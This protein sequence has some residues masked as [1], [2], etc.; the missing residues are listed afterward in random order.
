[1]LARRPRVRPRLAPVLAERA[2]Q[3]RAAPTAT[4]A[5]LWEQLRGSQLGVGF[6]RQL[7]IER[8][9]ADFACPARR[10][11]VEV[12]G[13]Y[14]QLPAAQRADARRDTVLARLGWRVVRV[15]AAEV[16]SQLPAVV[17]RIRVALGAV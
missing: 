10:L 6:R 16:Q 7:P 2:A 4:E 3:H 13:G 17:Q 15:T 8:F 14:H 1:M 9:I 5:L 12:D 11:V